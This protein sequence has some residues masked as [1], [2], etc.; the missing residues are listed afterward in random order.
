MNAYN[1]TTRLEKI[2]VDGGE[3]IL[4]TDVNDHGGAGLA[5]LP[6]HLIVFAKTWSSGLMTISDEGGATRTVSTPDTA[7]GEMGH[8]FP[9][10]LPDGRH[11]LITVWKKGTG[12]NDAETGILDL[13][14]GKHTILFKG[15]EARYLAPGFIVFYQPGHSTPSGSIRRHAR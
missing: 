13:E 9:S 14:S 10:P 11:L 15:F 5:W 2:A 1:R 3:P 7:R 8:L 4:I 6:N 12:I